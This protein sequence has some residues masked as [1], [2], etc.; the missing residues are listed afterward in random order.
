M[1]PLSLGS[2]LGSSMMPGA[3]CRGGAMEGQ[4]VQ[5]GAGCLR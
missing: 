3:A 4:E 2:G 5:G 1:E